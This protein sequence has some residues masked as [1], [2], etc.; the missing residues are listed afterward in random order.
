M[1]GRLARW[2]IFLQQFNFQI[3]YKPGKVNSDADTLSRRPDGGD[4][5]GPLVDNGDGGVGVGGGRYQATELKDSQTDLD[6][7]PITTMHYSPHFQAL[8]IF[9]QHSGVM[10]I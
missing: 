9:S 10:K 6:T 5:G 1:G 7:T 4:S 2:M 3:K 8:E